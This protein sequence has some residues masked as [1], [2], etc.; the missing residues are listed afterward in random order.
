MTTET[1]TDKDREDFENWAM[2]HRHEPYG[3]FGPGAL[4]RKEGTDSYEDDYIHGL[5]IA[6]QFWQNRALSVD[7]PDIKEMVTQL[8]RDLVI[9]CERAIKQRDRFL[10]TGVITAGNGG[11]HDTCFGWIVG[12]HLR[13]LFIKLKGEER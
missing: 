3:Y 1:T 9:E 11:S 5:W 2:N 12:N 10:E 6:R 8:D 7:Q 4:K 13:K